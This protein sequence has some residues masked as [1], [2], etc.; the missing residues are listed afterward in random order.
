MINKNIHY[1]WFGDNKKN[2]LVQNCIRSWHHHL[3]DYTITEWNEKNYDVNRSNFSKKA[4]REKKW[5]F[6]SDYARLD[7]LHENGGIYL[8]TD[9]EILK[10]LNNLLDC[11]LFIGMESET[12]VNGSIIGSIAGHWFLE[13]MLNE[14][15]KLE[16]YETIPVIMT[17]VLSRHLLLKN[18]IQ[19]RFDISIYPT[20]YF[21]P[22]G[23]NE[24][25]SKKKIT[26]NTYSIHWWNHSWSSH[27]VK[28]LKKLN[29]LN[30]VLWIKKQLF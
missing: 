15:D 25:F 5:A 12:H 28:V 13:E 7:V 16:T 21:Y 10:S 1:F 23:F 11:T 27:T 20:E 8:D 6:L 14:Y 18:I 3:A 4:F 30:S 24:K 19:Q 29:L 2:D 26:L 17:R 22:F 9:M